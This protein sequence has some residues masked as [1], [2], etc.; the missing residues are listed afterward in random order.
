MQKKR[1]V[2]MFI[3]TQ[4]LTQIPYANM[5]MCLMYVKLIGIG[6]FICRN[7]SQVFISCIGGEDF[8]VE[9]NTLGNHVIIY[10]Y[11]AVLM[12]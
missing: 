12:H 11:V 7:N 4:M 9:K 8:N 1:N 3:P 10:I 6:I 2:G 5:L